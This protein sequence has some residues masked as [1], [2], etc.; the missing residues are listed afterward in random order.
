MEVSEGEATHSLHI[1]IGDSM[2][3]SQRKHRCNTHCVQLRRLGTKR[4]TKIKSNYGAGIWH[5]GWTQYPGCLHA[6]RAPASQPLQLQPS[7]MLSC[8]RESAGDSSSTWIPAIQQGSYMES[9]LVAYGWPSRGHCRH[10]GGNL[11]HIGSFSIF[12]IKLKSLNKSINVMGDTE[13][14]KG[15][16]FRT[17]SN[18]PVNNIFC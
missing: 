15:R 5:C 10:V 6:V 18:K 3:R 16:F 7:L 2:N 12:Q 8:T 11:V 9:R 1:F 14:P 17:L 4:H 13:W